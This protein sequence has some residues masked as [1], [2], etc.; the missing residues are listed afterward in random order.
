MYLSPAGLLRLGRIDVG[1]DIYIV[2]NHDLPLTAAFFHHLQKTCAEPAFRVEIEVWGRPALE[3]RDQLSDSQIATSGV[4]NRNDTGC[5]CSIVPCIG[6]LKMISC[7]S[8]NA[9]RPVKNIP[10]TLAKVPSAA[11]CLEYASA[12]P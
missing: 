9:C 11:K 4:K 10:L 2:V 3:V 7:R 6:P 1:L 12:S 5:S 8:R